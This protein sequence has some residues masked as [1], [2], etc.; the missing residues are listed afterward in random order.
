VLAYNCTAVP[1]TLGKAGMLIN[2]KNYAEI[3]EMIQLVVENQPLREAIIRGQ[4]ARLAHFQPEKVLATL[5]H[6]LGLQT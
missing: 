2:T 3:A 4:T 5:F 6:Y 1:Y